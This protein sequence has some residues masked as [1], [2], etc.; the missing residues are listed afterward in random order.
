MLCNVF[1]LSGKQSCLMGKVFQSKEVVLILLSD[2]QS[3]AR[4]G[5]DDGSMLVDIF[6]SLF[7]ITSNSLV[8]KKI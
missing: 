4:V 2:S 3:D 6:W 5:K 1:K 7:S 8:R